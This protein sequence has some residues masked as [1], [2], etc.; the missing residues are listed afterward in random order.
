MTDKLRSDETAELADDKVSNGTEATENT[1][2]TE[3][4]ETA[5]GTETEET[6]QE[7]E[8]C[9]KGQDSMKEDEKEKRRQWIKELNLHPMTAHE[10]NIAL[11][12]YPNSEAATREVE[13]S[14]EPDDG[15]SP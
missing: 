6:L 4:S 7:L 5:E 3:D 11:E 9:L 12:H 13:R 2:S 8:L 15:F 14:R 1:K 10:I